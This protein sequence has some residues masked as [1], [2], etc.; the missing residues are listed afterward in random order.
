MSYVNAIL[1]TA[2]EKVKSIE[3]DAIGGGARIKAR[4]WHSS[5]RKLAIEA[6]SPPGDEAW[7]SVVLRHSADQILV[8]PV[9]EEVVSVH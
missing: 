2:L 1:S 5:F 4:R 3:P 9:P 7:N 8:I 6:P